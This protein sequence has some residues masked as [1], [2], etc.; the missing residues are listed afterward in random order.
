MPSAPD[1]SIDLN[2]IPT[3]L[4]DNVEVITGGASA[5]Y[6][7][8]AIAGVV[9][10]KLRRKFSGIEISGQVGGATQGDGRTNQ[11][12]AII[13][14]NFA[15]DRGNAVV[16]F[17][18]SDRA[19]VTGSSRP[20]FRDIRQ[21]NRPPEG[22]ILAGNFGSTGSPTIAAVNAVL[23]QYPGTTPIA[24]TGNYRG[25]IGVNTDTSVFTTLA[26]PNC[27]QNYRGLG[28]IPGLNISSNCTQVQ[29]ALGNYFDVQVPLEKYNAFAGASYELSD[30][31]TAYG[32]FNF[33]ETN[34]RDTT[35][36]GSTKASGRIILL[37]PQTSPFVTGNADLQTILQSITPT[38]TG[39]L[40]VTKLLS[41]FGNRVETFKYDVWQALGGFKGQIPG[42][43]LNYDIHASFGR[44]QFT[45]IGYGDV[46]LSRVNSILAGTADGAGCTGFAWNALGNNPLSAGCLAY[47]GRTIQNTNTQTQKVIEGTVDG[48]LFSLPAGE[49]RFAVGADHRI[50]DFDYQPD[51]ALIIGDSIPYDS[52][53]A[54]SGS[55][56]V[57]EA[58]AELLVPVLKDQPFAHE[59]VAG[60]GLSLFQI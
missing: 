44:S 12:G 29:V 58:F 39:P 21:L 28:A 30:N 24:G 50:N 17:E 26:T 10:F 4:I 27:V 51:N 59:L 45:N 48:A 38:P 6:G 55:Q 18:Y 41:Q 14:G 11:I 25:A 19:A 15:D 7:S 16:A 35:A 37:V 33:L 57:K 32:Q 60:L 2:T 34:A 53:S 5:T 9:N 23:A 40:K 56:N 36:S 31:I 43:Q 52:I 8:D 54:A 42:T 13:G 1:G 49:V 20:F 22:E 46:S 47:A 3:L